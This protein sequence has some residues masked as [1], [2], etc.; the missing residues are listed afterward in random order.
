MPSFHRLFQSEHAV[1][2]YFPRLAQ[3]YPK[4]VFVDLIDQLGAVHPAI[5]EFEGEIIGLS[6]IFFIP[7]LG[8]V[9]QNPPVSHSRPSASFPPGLEIG[10]LHDTGGFQHVGTVVPEH[11]YTAMAPGRPCGILYHRGLSG[12]GYLEDD[13]ALLVRVFL[14]DERVS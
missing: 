2:G 8:T 13:V 6:Q 12:L 1:G 14:I 10:Q 9:V 3:L 11:Y 5:V 4:L 7:D